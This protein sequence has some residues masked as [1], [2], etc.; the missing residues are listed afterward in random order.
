MTSLRRIALSAVGIAALLSASVAASAK[1]SID[2]YFPVPVQGALA[3]EMT[4][5]VK[6]FNDASPDVE[7]VAAYTGSYDDTRLKTQAAVEAGKPPAVTLMSAN[8]VQEFVISGEIEAIDDLLTENGGDPKAFLD[9]FWPAL[10]GNATANGKIYAIPFQ[11]STPILYINA[12]HFKEVGLDPAKPPATWAELVAAA[13]KLTK[14]DGDKISRYGFEMPGSYD[15]LGWL[16]QAFTMSNGGQFFNV[17]MPGEVYY[18]QPSTRGALQFLHDLAFT[19]K[20]M[21]EGVIDPN[22]VSTDFFAGKASMV[23]LSTGSLSFIR[24]GAKFPYT[25]AFVPRNLR[26][27]VPIGGGSLIVFKGITP[28]QRKAAWKFV[29]YMTSPETLGSWSRFTGYFAPRKSSYDL[30]EMKTFV[31]EHPD[32]LIAVKQLDY[33]QPWLS[34]YN[35]VAVRKAIEDQAQAVLSGKKQADEA[36]RDAQKNADEILRPYNEKIAH[37]SGL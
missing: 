13:T 30:Q 21:P 2:F 32:A 17:S 24:N 22:Q 25:V 35:V 28:E 37:V 19:H 20:V 15:Y 14:R 7:V 12:D 27:A 4:R 6:E 31:A 29:T 1:T 8:F 16:T 3:R 23:L 9:D 11:N 18:D 5:L 36:V 33:A 26:N 34:T 10:R